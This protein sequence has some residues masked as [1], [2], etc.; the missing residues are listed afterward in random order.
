MPQTVKNCFTV[1]LA[2]VVLTPFL[3]M[4]K[5]IKAAP[6]SCT[7]ELGIPFVMDAN[8]SRLAVISAI[9]VAWNG[10]TS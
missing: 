1:L 10:D 4:L 3:L 6:F 8:K 5:A 7:N 9:I 2:K